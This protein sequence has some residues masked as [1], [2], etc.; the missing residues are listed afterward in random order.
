MEDVLRA[1]NALVS[2]GVVRDYAIGGAVGAVFYIEPVQTDAFVFLPVEEGGL[3]DL[4][5][6]YRAL[7]R[8]GGVVEGEH[9]RFGTWPLQVLPDATALIAEAIS[10]AQTM[11]F[12]GVPVRVF[13]PEYLCCVA[14]QAGRAKDY[15][16]VQM[17]FEEEKVDLSAL[18][19]LAARY[20]LSDRL[21]K[22]EALRADGKI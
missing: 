7:E 5:P 14:L 10:N 20:S 13:R 9:V 12:A 1:L 18:R 11:E 3:I 8:H 21:A 16:R 15:L 19:D 4:S 2:E 6:I 22:A 17:F